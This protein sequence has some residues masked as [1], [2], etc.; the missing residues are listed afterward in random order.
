LLCQARVTPM[1]VV[2]IIQ[3]KYYFTE[4]KCNKLHCWSKLVLF[5]KYQPP[6][7]PGVSNGTSGALR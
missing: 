2:E 6:G 3:R 5:E 7:N 1:Q 4:K